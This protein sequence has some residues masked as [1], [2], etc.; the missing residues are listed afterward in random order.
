MIIMV[1]Y[2]YWDN[3][4]GTRRTNDSTLPSEKIKFSQYTTVYRPTLIIYMY[5]ILL[6][7]HYR[8]MANYRIRYTVKNAFQIFEDNFHTEKMSLLLLHIL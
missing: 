1:H 7:I 5:T 2:K 4:I 3:S 6:F 8:I